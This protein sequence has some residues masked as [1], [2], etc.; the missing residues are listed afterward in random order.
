V[1]DGQSFGGAQGFDNQEKVVIVFLEFWPLMGVEDILEHQRVDGELVADGLDH[2]NNVKPFAVD[3]EG[4]PRVAVLKNVVNGCDRVF[5]E[6]IDAVTD[7]GDTASRGGFLADM[8]QGAWRQT[9]LFGRV[10]E[11]FGHALLLG[12]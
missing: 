10:I 11:G 9:R 4:R 7:Q 3:P 6:M 12:W 1:A 5:F 8:N 2:L